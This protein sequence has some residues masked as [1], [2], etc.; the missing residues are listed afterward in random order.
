MSPLLEKAWEKVARLP[1]E[2]REAIAWQILG[3]LAEEDAWKRRFAE[4]RD[5]IARMAREAL[6][7]DERGETIGLDELV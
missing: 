2:E 6:A 1:E 4:R 5:V 7:E 3:W